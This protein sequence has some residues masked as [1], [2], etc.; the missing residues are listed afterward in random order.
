MPRFANDMAVLALSKGD[1]E[2]AL[3]EI[4][5]ILTKVVI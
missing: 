2:M 3:R 4:E 5:E 1:L